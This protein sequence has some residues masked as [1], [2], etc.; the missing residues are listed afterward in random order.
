MERA[1]AAM[2]GFSKDAF[3][4]PIDGHDTRFDIYRIG[5]GAPVILMQEMPGIG[6][7]AIALCKRLAGAGF[8]V[9]AP[10]WF[11]PL[12]KATHTNVVRILCMRREFQLFAKN[13][14][15]AIV[16]W[17]RALCRHVAQVRG[18]ER[19][20]VIG[21]CLSGNFAMTLIAEPNVWAAVA[22]QPSLPGRAPGALHMS[23]SE[24]A[25]SH[26][27]LDTKGAMHAYRFAGDPLCTQA[28]FDAIDSAFNENGVR[29]RL[30]ILPGRGHSVF[31]GHFDE[32]AGAPTAE[33]LTDVIGYLKA[34]LNR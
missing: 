1:M 26:A 28:K 15:S 30:N 27:A 33:A 5:A 14:S 8:E 20:G 21:M 22:S 10:H 23:A 18:V 24:I 7:E 6:P 19:V 3:S 32:T 16:D 13:K 17:M 2:D 9:W 25:A 31:T 11:G 12:G 34:Q 29:V 4:A